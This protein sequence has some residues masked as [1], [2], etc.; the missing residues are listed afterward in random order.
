MQASLRRSPSNVLS[1]GSWEV[2]DSLTHSS[3]G[4]KEA[5]SERSSYESS[6]SRQASQG[7]RQQQ[8]QR[9]AEPASGGPSVV[10]LWA[11]SLYALRRQALGKPSTSAFA[12]LPALAWAESPNKSS[13]GSSSS[14][15]SSSS[16]GA[17]LY[18]R[19]MTTLDSDLASLIAVHLKRLQVCPPVFILVG[20]GPPSA[21]VQLHS[22]LRPEVPGAASLSAWASGQRPAQVWCESAYMWPRGGPSK[23]VW[24]CP[25][26][27]TLTPTP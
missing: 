13:G 6:Y 10:E 3:E 25:L 2:S 9:P 1:D 15:S 17:H 19:D 18:A 24:R 16:G 12:T 20:S 23:V 8:W 5:P 14:S 21:T 11:R 7:D 4:G 27:E 22:G 26:K